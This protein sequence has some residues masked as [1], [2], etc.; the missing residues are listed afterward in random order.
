MSFSVNTSVPSVTTGLNGTSL[1]RSLTALSSGSALS[2]A[3]YDASGLSVADQLSAQVS[4]MG[5]AIRNSNDSV[6][7]LQIADG[8]LQEYGN[9]LDEV[10]TL[11]LKASNGTLNDNNRQSIQNEIDSLLESADSIAKNTS[12][13]GISLLDGTGGDSGDGTFVTQT[14]ADAG[15]NVSVT[16]VNA[17]TSSLLSGTID[18]TTAAGAEAALNVIDDVLVCVDSMRSD[19]GAAQNSIMSSIRNT[20]VT[21]TNTAFA[22]SQIRDVDFAAESANFSQANL[23]SQIS[24]FTQAQANASQANVLNALQ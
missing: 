4:G 11:T 12:Y 10:R 19:L 17:Q 24:A 15:N 2:S 8:G 1:D 14:G 13:N 16:I 3:A 23:F 6:G 9:I 5:Q 21:Q 7:M 20:S 22:E 18:V